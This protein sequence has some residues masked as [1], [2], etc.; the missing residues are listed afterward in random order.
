[1]CT[2]CI[3]SLV[4]QFLSSQCH[5]Y[6]LLWH[7]GSHRI[8]IVIISNIISLLHL[9]LI[10][11][12][13]TPIEAVTMTVS[14]SSPGFLELVLNSPLSVFGHLSQGQPP[15]WPLQEPSD[16]SWLETDCPPWA[17]LVLSVFGRLSQWPASRLT[18]LRTIWSE[19]TQSR[20]S[21]LACC[22]KKPLR[23]FLGQFMYIVYWT[24]IVYSCIP[25]QFNS[26]PSVQM[27]CFNQLQ[28]VSNIVSL[29]LIIA[30]LLSEYC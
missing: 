11:S 9:T 12:K 7:T 17:S 14:D 21:P 8:I 19:W 28:F 18:V 22:K 2:Y 3:L 5:C 1:M 24:F 20:H 30:W 25:N 29:C 15:T 6:M 16:R 26:F 13:L 4:E 10:K 27:L 23:V